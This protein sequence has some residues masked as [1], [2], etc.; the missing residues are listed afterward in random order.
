MRIAWRE[1]LRRGEE[2][3]PIAGM[4]GCSVGRSNFVFLSRCG[5][6]AGLEEG[7]GDHGHQ[8]VFGYSDRRPAFEMGGERQL[9]LR[10]RLLSHPSGFDRGGEPHAKAALMSPRAVLNHLKAGVLAA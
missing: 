9:E 2:A 10:M 4:R 1:A 7:A 6:A 3:C 8:G 5:E